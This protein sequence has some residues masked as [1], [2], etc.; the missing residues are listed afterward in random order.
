MINTM[1]KEFH[2]KNY[3]SFH[4]RYMDL[5]EG[6]VEGEIFSSD[7]IRMKIYR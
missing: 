2:R 6:K 4:Y 3:Y 7:E 1:E 5:Y